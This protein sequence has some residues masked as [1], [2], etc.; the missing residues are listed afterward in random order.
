MLAL[1]RE[2]FD[3]ASHPELVLF[4]CKVSVDGSPPR[5]LSRSSL[6]MFRTAA[7]GR[8]E[9]FLFLPD[10]PGGRRLLVR[11][12]FSTGENHSAPFSTVEKK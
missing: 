4:H 5:E 2:F 8:R 9:A 10:P 1:R 6:V 7:P 3:G 11:Y 12:F